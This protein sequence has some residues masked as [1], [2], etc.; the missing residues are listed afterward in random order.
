MQVKVFAQ[1]SFFC[2]CDYRDIAVRNILV[3]KLDCVKLGD[4]GLSRYIEE[5]EEYYKG[6]FKI[7]GIFTITYIFFLHLFFIFVLDIWFF[8]FRYVK[9]KIIC[10]ATYLFSLVPVNQQT[11]NICS[12]VEASVSRLPIKW[13]APES[14]NFR[15]FTSASD[16]W[17]FGKH[18]MLLLQHV[19]Q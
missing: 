1:L 19:L 17:M 3:A 6:K 4:F 8:C 12:L 14:I 7:T 13:M 11:L 10:W 2:L 5:E 9:E 18:V 16:V 15:R